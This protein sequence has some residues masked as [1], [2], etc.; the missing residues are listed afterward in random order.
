MVGVGHCAAA[1]KN[2]EAEAMGELFQTAEGEVAVIALYAHQQDVA[3]AAAGGGI[4]PM[5]LRRFP[6]EYGAVA[7]F[8]KAELALQILLHGGVLLGGDVILA[9]IQKYADVEMLA[10][11]PLHLIGLAGHFGSHV[12]QAVIPRLGKEPLEVER[13]RRG[14]M[15][16]HIGASAVAAGGGA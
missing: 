12:V 15:G 5:K 2:G 10:V 11:D 4:H 1:L 9:E 13:F 8:Q 3:A 6:T 16:V 14:E 7:V